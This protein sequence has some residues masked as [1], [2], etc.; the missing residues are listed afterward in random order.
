MWHWDDTEGFTYWAL[1]TLPLRAITLRPCYDGPINGGEGLNTSN[2]RNSWT[3]NTVS[4]LTPS[5]SAVE[6]LDTTDV[7]TWSKLREYKVREPLGKDVGE[8]RSRQDMKH[9]NVP[10]G[11]ALTEKVKVNLNMLSALVLNGVGEK[12]DNTDIVAVD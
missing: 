8:L 11:N 9:M 2:T 3:P 5:S 10:D 12:I 4:S 6:T 1:E 7:D